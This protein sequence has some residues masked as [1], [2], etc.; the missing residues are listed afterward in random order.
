M[1]QEVI[2]AKM[3]PTSKN[4]LEEFNIDE[5]RS[6]KHAITGIWSVLITP[7][8]AAA[9]DFAERYL[10]IFNLV[11]QGD[12]HLAVGVHPATDTRRRWTAN[13]E[14]QK[15]ID[16]LRERLGASGERIPDLG[17]VFFDPHGNAIEDGCV[18]VPLDARL[19]GNA[20][21]YRAGFEATHLAI[22]RSFEACGLNPYDKVPASSTN[23]L[24]RRLDQELKKV[25]VTGY[26][27]SFG[28][29]VANA[30]LGAAVG[31]PFG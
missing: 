31:I 18:I 9:V 22:R 11:V 6:G 14:F 28:F 15:S 2:G 1:K 12:W 17:I 29:A 27:K 30:L 4:T 7:S 10:E 21:L 13:F 25:K 8:A 16:E 3:I 20:N 5:V 24:L 23:T 19:I 26:F